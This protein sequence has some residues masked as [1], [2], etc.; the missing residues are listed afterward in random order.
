MPVVEIEQSFA[1]PGPEK[2]EGPDEQVGAEQAAGGRVVVTAGEVELEIEKAEEV[3]EETEERA[4][5]ADDLK[6]FGDVQS[7]GVSAF[8]RVGE[9][10]FAERAMGGQDFCSATFKAIP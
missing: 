10:V 7:A 6:S 2:S 9:I 5:L 4:V 3:G 1:D 8:I